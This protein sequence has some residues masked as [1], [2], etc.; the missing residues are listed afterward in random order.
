MRKGPI[1]IT[2][3]EGQKEKPCCK[4]IKQNPSIL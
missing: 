3:H 2:G 1:F 4:T